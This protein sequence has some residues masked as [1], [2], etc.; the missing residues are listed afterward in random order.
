MTAV[1][2][3][4]LRDRLASRAIRAGFDASST[5]ETGRLLETLAAS[6]PG[7]A[8]LELGTGMGLGTAWRPAKSRPR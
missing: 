7:G 3:D 1:P 8:F 4:S 2:S 5:A 6:K